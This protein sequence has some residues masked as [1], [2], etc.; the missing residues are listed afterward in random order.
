MRDCLLFLL[1]LGVGTAGE[2]ACVDRARAPAMVERAH[3]TTAAPW[4]RELAGTSSTGQIGARSDRSA[5]GPGVRSE[6]A[7]IGAATLLF[8]AVNPDERLRHPKRSVVEGSREDED[9]FFTDYVAHPLSRGL[10]GCCLRR[11]GHS[12]RSALLWR[13]GHSLFWEYVLE[14]IHQKPSGKDLIADF[15]SACVGLQIGSPTIRLVTSQK[16]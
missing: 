4:D 12:G 14:G 10:I 3:R 1:A 5:T 9:P 8:P 6:L 7:R 15:A 11:R 2:S 13:R 16:A